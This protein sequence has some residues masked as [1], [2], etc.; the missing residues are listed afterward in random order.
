V[1]EATYRGSIVE[2]P[3]DGG[4]GILPPHHHHYDHA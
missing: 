1:L 4:R 3:G 2:V